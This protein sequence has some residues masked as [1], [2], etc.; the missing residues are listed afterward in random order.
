MILP[1]RIR[2][3][4]TR[5][6]VALAFE[7]QMRLFGSQIIRFDPLNRLITF[8]MRSEGSMHHYALHLTRDYRLFGEVS[9]VLA[10]RFAGFQHRGT[11]ETTM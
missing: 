4:Q 11:L 3:N 7:L 8:K 9:F 1:T 6:A 10:S 2:D 5:T